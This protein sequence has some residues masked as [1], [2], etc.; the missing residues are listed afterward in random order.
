MN[1]DRERLK[2]EM[3][4]HLGFLERS[5]AFLDAGEADGAVRMAVSVRVLF[6]STRRQTA[7][8]DHLGGLFR[9]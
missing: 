1:T 8:I 4:R 2:Q 5:C 3:R 6:H 7:L 9:S